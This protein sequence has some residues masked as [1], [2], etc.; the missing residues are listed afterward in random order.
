M[1]L[2]KSYKNAKKQCI[3]SKDREEKLIINLQYN[4]R[5]NENDSDDSDYLLWILLRGST[6]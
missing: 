6:N 5:M 1:S 3:P 2:T 4:L